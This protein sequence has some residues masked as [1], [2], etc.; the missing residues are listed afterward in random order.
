MVLRTVKKVNCSLLP[1]CRK[2]LKK[3]LLR[4]NFMSQMWSKADEKNPT[5]SLLPEEYG[6]IRIEQGYTA[7]WYD[8]HVLPSELEQHEH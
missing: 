2:A 3:K 8:G 1:P 7:N 4:V 6:W 5:A